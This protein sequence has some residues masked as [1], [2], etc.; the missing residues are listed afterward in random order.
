MASY[1]LNM[2]D[3][4]RRINFCRLNSQ[5]DKFDWRKKICGDE[6]RFTFDSHGI[7]SQYFGPSSRNVERQVFV[8]ACLSVQGP[9]MIRVIE[10]KFDTRMYIAL[11]Q[12]D[13]LPHVSRQSCFIQDHFP[14]HVASAVKT[15]M[16]ENDFHLFPSWP[17]KS[18]D[19]MPLNSVFSRVLMDVNKQH[20]PILSKEMLWAEIERHFSLLSTDDAYVTDIFDSMPVNMKR[21]VVNNGE[22][23]E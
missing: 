6:A 8:W 13:V 3:K 7:V 23:L 15:W 14:V 22:L 11:L 18:G 1:I 19:I 20:Q 16:K 10:E 9:R 4:E 21:V 17:E 12:R 2:F 5:L